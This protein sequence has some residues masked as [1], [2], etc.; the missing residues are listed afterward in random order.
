MHSMLEMEQDTLVIVCAPH[1]EMI[2]SDKK[3]QKEALDIIKSCGFEASEHE[4][5]FEEGGAELSP[6]G[7]EQQ[8]RA[9]RQ[10]QEQ[11]LLRQTA[12]GQLMEKHPDWE[13]VTQTSSH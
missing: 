10:Q 7:L 9:L 13:D 2:L 5:R 12:V 11:Q 1:F 6:Y 8:R 3:R 4:F